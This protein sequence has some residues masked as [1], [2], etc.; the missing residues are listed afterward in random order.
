MLAKAVNE[1]AAQTAPGGRASTAVGWTQLEMN[2]VLGH[3][4]PAEQGLTN[5]GTPA[6]RGMLTVR[7]RR[8]SV[9]DRATS[10][11]RSAALVR[12]HEGLQPAAP[13]DEVLAVFST[14]RSHPIEIPTLCE[15]DH[16]I[17]S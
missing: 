11:R 5:S 14:I 8:L 13:R 9:R 3:P 10:W 6:R 4:P 7:A 15:G 1:L 2:A 12:G 17:R 16:R